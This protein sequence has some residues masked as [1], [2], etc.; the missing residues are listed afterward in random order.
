MYFGML[1]LAL[2]VLG[3]LLIYASSLA[4]PG[5]GPGRSRL[6]ILGA[7]LIALSIIAALLA[8]ALKSRLSR[9]E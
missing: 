2:F 3:A 1:L 4:D 7:E 9:D 8:A 6:R 5:S